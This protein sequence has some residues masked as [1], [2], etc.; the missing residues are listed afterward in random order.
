[1]PAKN[2]NGS[3][4][5][6]D[7]WYLVVALVV[8]VG[9]GLVAALMSGGEEE[10]L[11]TGVIGTAGEGVEVVRVSDDEM[12]AKDDVQVGYHDM[13]AE[14]RDK[15]YVKEYLEK[16][17]VDSDSDAAAGT[18]MSLAVVYRRQ[19]EFDDAAMVLEEL[20]EKFPDSPNARSARI[21]LPEV[22][23]QAGDIPMAR[24]S[25]QRMMEHFP[26]ESQEHQWAQKRYSEL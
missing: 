11:P 16:L 2:S 15:R 26:P 20:L 1:M 21:Q 7:N 13:T 5:L 10:P 9:G 4:I 19:G 22:Y 24:T 18:M 25:Y 14:E 3:S 6:K 17:E 23:Q 12:L 8:L